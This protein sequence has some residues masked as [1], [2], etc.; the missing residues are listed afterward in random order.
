M[1]NMNITRI[2]EELAKLNESHI[3]ELK[4]I[5]NVVNSIE[6]EKMEMKEE[7]NEI[8]DTIE[9]Q[10]HELLSSLELQIQRGL[11]RAD[12]PHLFRG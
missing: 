3:P 1:L 8:L 5:E 6:S 2:K 7:L 12:I 9:N 11:R 10:E 4:E